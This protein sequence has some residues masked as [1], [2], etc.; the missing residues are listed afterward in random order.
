VATT[1]VLNRSKL[2]LAVDDAKE[3]LSLVQAA[4]GAAGYSFIGA[5]SGRE[6]LSLLTR[7]QPKVILLDIE[8]PELDGFETC[9]IIRA[10]EEPRARVPIVFLTAR[11]T[12]ED[13]KRCIAVGGND[14]I[15]KPFDLV[16]LLDRIR[17][18]ASGSVVLTH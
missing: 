1:T 6:C 3:N 13:V 8:M 17:H 4:V 12:A 16:K 14:F 9:R 10:T 18:W 15:I 11:K 7:I 5:S 2:V